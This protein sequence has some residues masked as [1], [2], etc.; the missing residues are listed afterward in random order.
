[1]IWVSLE[2]IVC[3]TCSFEDCDPE[4]CQR[5][6]LRR[7]RDFVV[8]DFTQGKHSKNDDYWKSKK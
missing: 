3:D 6:L 7:F 4:N 2:A 8:Q 5:S 1:M